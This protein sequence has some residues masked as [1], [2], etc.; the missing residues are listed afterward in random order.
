M[1]TYGLVFTD[2]DTAKRFTI[3][4]ANV[5][6]RSTVRL[7]CIER[8]V[9][10]LTDPGWA[11]VVNLSSVSDGSFDVTVFAFNADAYPPPNNVFPNEDLTLHYSLIN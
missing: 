4:D 6:A 2:G 9:P 5:T 1:A 11:Y 10:E 8:R 7:Y 3:T